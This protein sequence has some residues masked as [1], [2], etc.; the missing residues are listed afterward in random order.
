M[1]RM[2]GRDA[3]KRLV[4]MNPQVRVLFARGYSAEHITDVGAASLSIFSLV[5]H[6]KQKPDQRRDDDDTANHDINEVLRQPSH[7]GPFQLFTEE[8]K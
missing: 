2:S 4:E 7:E 5:A 3:F 1:P 8:R 6:E